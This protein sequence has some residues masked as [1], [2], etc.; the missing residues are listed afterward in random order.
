MSAYL[1]VEHR[2]T[3]LE[4]FAEYSSKVR[5][6]LAQYG[7]RI[8]T[9]GGGHKVLET[10]HWLPERVAIFEF[11]DRATLDTWFSSPEYQPLAALRQAAVDMDKDVMIAID[12]A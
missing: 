12:G 4:K 8:L 7:A 1:I 11:P 6:M 5:P 10:S 9:G 2:I 3:D